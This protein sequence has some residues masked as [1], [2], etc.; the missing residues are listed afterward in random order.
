[1]KYI[2]TQLKKNIFVQQ[3]N[4]FYLT[5]IFFLSNL[6]L[7]LSHQSTPSKNSNGLI[8]KDNKIT[9]ILQGNGTQN[10]LYSKFHFGNGGKEKIY[11]VLVNGESKSSIVRET[12]TYKSN[13]D[14][15]NIT[16]ILYQPISKCEKMFYKTF[17]H[18]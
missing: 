1:M 9:Y 18:I 14:I 17:F 15:N 8:H 16:L 11:D 10:F 6:L 5:Q 3:Y 12:K 7:I 4:L 2:F 13:K